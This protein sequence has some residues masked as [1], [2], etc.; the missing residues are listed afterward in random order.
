MP[1][2]QV[3][4]QYSASGGV[5]PY[6]AQWD[7]TTDT[8]DSLDPPST[9]TVLSFDDVPFSAGEI[10]TAIASPIRM[11]WYRLTI[12]DANGTVKDAFVQIK[13]AD[14]L[15]VFAGGDR[16]ITPGQEV[17]I[18]PTV[19]GGVAPYSYQ[20]TVEDGGDGGFISATDIPA[21]T[22]APSV[23]TTY[24]LTVTDS[25]ETSVSDTVTV[26]LGTGEP[27]EENGTDN[28]ENGSAGPDTNDTGS[29]QSLPNVGG[30]DDNDGPMPQSS[31]VVEST[32]LPVFSLPACGGGMSSSLVMLTTLLLAA[33][34]SRRRRF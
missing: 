6:T 11:T 1:G 18:Y 26:T 23:T 4:L 28:A 5:P 24:V 12:T 21:V 2:G 3:E 25:I 8:D 30:E 13:V 31:P 15:E 14:E 17:T 7:P 9:V 16:A 33:M 22:V 20:W 32:G 10:M 27:T 19:T 29:G 34:K